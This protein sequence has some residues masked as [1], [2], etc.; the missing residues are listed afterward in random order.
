MSNR[1]SRADDRAIGAPATGAEASGQRREW[2][3]LGKID[4]LWAIL[5]DPSKRHRAW[6]LAEFM[7][8]GEAEVSRL[9]ELAAQLGRPSRLGRALDFG[10]GVGR[11]TRALA[12]RFEVAIGVDIAYTMLEQAQELGGDRKNLSFVHNDRPDLQIFEDDGF[13]LVY[14]RLVLQHLPNTD[15]IERH[16]EEF[17]RVLRPTGLLVFQLPARIPVRHRIQLRRRAFVALRRLGFSERVLLDRFELTPIR[18]V[19]ISP[20]RVRR[21][22]DGAGVRILEAHTERI[23]GTSID[24]VTYYATKDVGRSDTMP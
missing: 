2:E 7:A 18:M 13:D 14:S 3:A 22:L 6:S 8:T 16:I 19:G 23:P 20:D 12:D 24:S 11:I 21:L 4:P 17:G 5:S 10:C 15:Q 1:T 9:L